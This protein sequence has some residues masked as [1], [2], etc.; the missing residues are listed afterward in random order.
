MDCTVSSDLV[1]TG[2]NN[3]ALVRPWTQE[4]FESSSTQWSDL[5]ARSEADPLFMSWEWQWLWWKHH[6][7]PQDSELYVLAGYNDAG[8]LVGLAPLYLHRATHRGLSARRLESI[9][10]SFR[11]RAQVFSEY[12]D[13]IID[14][15]YVD[16]FLKALGEVI[17]GDPRWND[18]VFANTPVDG[19]AAHLLKVHLRDHYVRDADPLTSY[20]VALPADFASYVSS[21][22]SD[23]RRRAWNQRK[24]LV[25]PQLVEIHVAQVDEALNLIDRFHKQRW[26]QSHYVG[27]RRL[28]NRAFAQLMGRRGELHITELHSDGRPLNVMYNVRVGGREYNIQSGFDANAGKGISPGYLHLGFALERASEHGVKTFDFLAGKGL[29][30]DY[31]RDFCTQPKQLITLQS[32]RTKALAW[33]YRGYDKRFIRSLGTLGPPIG[34]LTDAMVSLDSISESTAGFY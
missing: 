12:L 15:R 20:S 17:S 23:T 10:S 6:C 4:E 26:G 16:S 11:E 28:F 8:V 18:L 34:L 2:P 7:I 19:H 31:K 14:V 22:D 5:L 24:K 13:L 21:L 29:N 25:N 33:L 30:R 1:N 9:G 27:F 3:V 32:I